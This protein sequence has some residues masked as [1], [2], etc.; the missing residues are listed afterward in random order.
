MMGSENLDIE[1][2]GKFLVLF[3][4]C[5]K[6]A[7]ASRKTIRIDLEFF[8]YSLFRVWSFLTPRRGGGGVDVRKI[9]KMFGTP[10]NEA[11]KCFT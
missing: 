8:T 5:K 11:L 1:N 9:G 7:M 2:C 10:P 3:F 6:S 4:F